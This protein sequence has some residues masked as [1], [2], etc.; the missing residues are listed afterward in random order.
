MPKAFKMQIRVSE[1]GVAEFEKNEIRTLFAY[2]GSNFTLSKDFMFTPSAMIKIS[3]MPTQLDLNAIFG[4]KNLI[5]FGPL[6]RSNLTQLDN[7]FN[8]AGFLLG[9][10]F[11]RNWYLGYVYEIPLSDIRSA[12]LQTH[13]ISLR[14]FWGLQ[15]SKSIRSPRYFL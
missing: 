11:W 9:V 1:P 4:Y 13:E 8:S 14:F 3:T 12:T 2:G 5:D 10:S 7:W 15:K 6:V